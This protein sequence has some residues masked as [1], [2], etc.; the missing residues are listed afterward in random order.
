MGNLGRAGCG[1]SLE[2]MWP[3]TYDSCDLGTL[4]NQTDP[5]TNLPE[6][7]HV[8]GTDDTKGELSYLPGQRLSACTCET[9]SDGRDGQQ[10]V[11]P[12]PR[13]SDKSF[14]GRGAPEI[15]IFEATVN[16]K[17]LVGEVSQ[18]V[19]W[20]PFNA[21]HAWD[22][23]PTNMII[24]DSSQSFFNPFVG[25]EFQQTTSVLSYTAQDCYTHGA[26]C[27][28][29]YGFEY[30]PGTDGY[31]QWVND[32]KPSWQLRAA[33]MG[34]DSKTMIGARPVPEEPMY[35][36]ANLGISEGFGSIDF[37]H[38]VFPAYMLI[39]YIR[40]YQPSNKRNVGC[41]PPNFPTADYI[42]TYAHYFLCVVYS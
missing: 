31:I 6:A 36:L 7:A 23:S 14:V 12:G 22:N 11:H 9:E 19:Q 28:T 21:M 33:G 24:D 34:P 25:N 37:E 18:S 17:T 1:A 13:R 41:D 4:R 15:D 29:T 39:D 35:I 5:F 8:G 3:Y 30:T 26:G 40:V 16:P 2:G 27:F 20:A 38:L 42:N 32:A 10:M